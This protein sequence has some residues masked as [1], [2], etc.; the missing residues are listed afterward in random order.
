MAFLTWIK[1]VHRFLSGYPENQLRLVQ[2][3]LFSINVLIGKD[4]KKYWLQK[5]L[6]LEFQIYFTGEKKERQ[7]FQNFTLLD[8]CDTIEKS[9]W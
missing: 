3:H 9:A 4:N 7:F 6:I 1:K 8:V 5:S 2:V